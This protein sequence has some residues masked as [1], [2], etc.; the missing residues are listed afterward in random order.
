MKK[1]YL[2]FIC[3]LFSTCIFC[4][5]RVPEFFGIPID[6]TKEEMIQKLVETGKFIKCVSGDKYDLMLI[7]EDFIRLGVYPFVKI[8]THD[9]KVAII[10]QDF[11]NLSAKVAKIL[12]NVFVERF[13][14][15]SEF[16]VLK[17][18]L[19]PEK[20]DIFY[21]MRVNKKEYK[22]IVSNK[23]DPHDISTG[24]AEGLERCEILNKYIFLIEGCVIEEMDEDGKFMIINK[25]ENVRNKGLDHCSGNSG[26]IE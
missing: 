3:L 17:G 16:I 9:S 12:F 2:I 19:I 14:N 20:E 11:L 26:K 23:I 22:L 4:Q 5:E 25:W 13:S 24:F 1:F 6:G 18:D 10:Q 21:E 15:D 8:Y 7:N